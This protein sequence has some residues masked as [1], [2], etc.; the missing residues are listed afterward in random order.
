MRSEPVH[1]SNLAAKVTT[2][3]MVRAAGRQEIQ[4][5]RITICRF[6]GNWIPFRNR[7][8]YPQRPRQ[9]RISDR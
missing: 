6:L 5:L 7:K 8:A 2:M 1:A 3:E 4:S 9:R